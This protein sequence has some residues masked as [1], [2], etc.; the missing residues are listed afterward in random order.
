VTGRVIA[1]VSVALAASSSVRS[2]HAE[3][4]DGYTITTPSSETTETFPIEDL[5]ATARP[6]AIV[7]MRFRNACVVVGE[8]GRYA[9]AYRGLAN[10][11]P[12]RG[13]LT[14][15]QG[16][17]R[18][19]WLEV[20]RGEDHGKIFYT[21]PLHSLSRAQLQQIRGIS[22]YA[23]SDEIAAD[24]ARLDLTHVCLATTVEEAISKSIAAKIRYLVVDGFDRD[25]SGIGN[26][27]NLVFLYLNADLQ[28][29]D[30][31]SIG[32]LTR[33]QDLDLSAETLG[34]PDRLKTLQALRRLTLRARTPLERIDFVRGM[35]NLQRLTLKSAV[36]LTPIEGLRNLVELDAGASAASHLPAVALPALRKANLMSTKVADAEVERFRALNPN[37]VVLHRWTPQLRARLVGASEVEIEKLAIVRGD[38][39]YSVTVR[40]AAEVAKLVAAIEIADPDYFVLGCLPT[41]RLTF[42]RPGGPPNG[43]TLFLANGHDVRWEFPG[44]APLTSASLRDVR[45]WLA[46]HGVEWTDCDGGS[47]K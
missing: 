1:I 8:P 47:A 2:A 18:L 27:E 25:L 11:G 5:S 34:N 41:H 13:Y 44:D 20:S 15:A 10:I 16:R 38:R 6:T 26:F 39:T 14:D 43:E 36:D 4:A 19:V 32:A 37:A 45:A 24:L 29:V 7:H 17:R 9:F 21:N 23:W 46:R 40:D 33:L 35:P 3:S 12:A 22:L 30:A 42:K 31:T 28:P